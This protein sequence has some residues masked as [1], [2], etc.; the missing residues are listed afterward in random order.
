MTEDQQGQDAA[1]TVKRTVTVP[2]DIAAHIDGQPNRSAYVTSA[3]RREMAVDQL[4]TL[5]TER[6]I[7]VDPARVG[8]LRERIT[9][10]EQARAA[11]TRAA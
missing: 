7:V 8:R 9:A 1:K 4:R 11:E 3:L 10:M 2:A 6:G 5:F